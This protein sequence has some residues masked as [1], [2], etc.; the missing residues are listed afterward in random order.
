LHLVLDTRGSLSSELR[1]LSVRL[2]AMYRIRPLL[3]DE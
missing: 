1:T 3:P 2:G